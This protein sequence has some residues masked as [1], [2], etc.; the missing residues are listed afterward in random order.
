MEKFPEQ[1]IAAKL[2]QFGRLS[3]KMADVRSSMLE[4]LD[5]CERIQT[6]GPWR[7]LRNIDWGADRHHATQWLNDLLDA[8]PIPL[9]VRGLWFAAPE[10]EY[11]KPSTW[12]VGSG[13]FDTKDFDWAC[14]KVWPPEIA[15]RRQR[16]PRAQST[17]R[18][19]ALSQVQRIFHLEP[20]AKQTM[21]MLDA[22]QFFRYALPLGYTIA[23]LADVLPLVWPTLLLG[24]ARRRGV[25]CGFQSG[26][27]VGLGWI[28][29]SGW[30]T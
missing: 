25:A 7:A 5:M 11:S 1:R 9:N 18:L 10:V 13:N 30:S 27:G 16:R 12:V 24:G 14:Q 23:L 3:V 22:A 28:T 2:D 17:F 4:F 15:P 8:Y 21:K 29:K 19:S 20:R 6:R 26:D